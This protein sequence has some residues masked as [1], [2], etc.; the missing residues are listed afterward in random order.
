MAQRYQAPF[1]HGLTRRLFEAVDAPRHVADVIAEMLVGAN[2]RGHDSHGILRVPGYLEGFQKGGGYPAEEPTF[3]DLGARTG[4]CDG[5]GGS[6]LY[7]AKVATEHAIEKARELETYRITVKNMGHIGR[8]G[9]YA[10]IAAEAGCIGIITSGS[11][12]PGRG[13][14]LPYGGSK[15]ALGTNP[16]AIGVPTG[17]DAPFVIDY[18]TSA[19]AAGKMFFAETQGKDLREDCIVDKEGQPT[20][21]VQDYYDGGN[22]LAFGRHKGYAM[23]LVVSLLGG[24][25]GGL[26]PE[27][28]SMGGCLIQIMNVEAFTPLNAYQNGVRAFLDNIKQTPP[29]TG[30]N[31]VLVPGD[32]EDIARRDRL[33]NGIEVWDMTIDGIREWADKL[34]VNWNDDLVEASDTERYK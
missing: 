30:F 34:D 12:G 10:E 17:D 29:A 14:I 23:S 3:E 28:Q 20:V 33:T 11:G 18:A 19:I 1:L 24:L 16:M 26:D 5:G 31:E 13:R 21:K 2:L 27:A 15:P 22:L 4:S 8:L 9:A 32:P 6:G 7:T 25:T